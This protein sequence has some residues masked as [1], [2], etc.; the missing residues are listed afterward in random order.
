M[1]IRNIK[2]KR[3]QEEIV[4]FVLIIV[5]VVVISLIF[6]AISLKKPQ[7]RLENSELET[8]VQSSLKYTTIC[9]ESPEKRQNIKELIVNCNSGGKCLNNRTACSVLNETVSDMMKKSWKV[10]TSVKSY[11]LKIYS[12]LNKTILEVK[13]G[14]CTGTKIG[15]RVMI[16]GGIR[17]EFEI[18]K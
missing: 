1:K 5:L 12:A 17:E 7:E 11:N 18:C 10:G 14:N 6:L 15:A 9:Y 13:D 4:G 8:F 2:S 16:L 3:S